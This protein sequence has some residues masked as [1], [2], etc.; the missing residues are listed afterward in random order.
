MTIRTDL[1]SP[2]EWHTLQLA[3]LWVFYL[4]AGADQEIDDREKLVFLQ[5][6]LSGTGEE[7]GSTEAGFRRDVLTSLERDLPALIRTLGRDG[8][9]PLT[10]LRQVAGV[11]NRKT[12]LET[13]V[14]FKESLM[15]IGNRVAGASGRGRYG[16]EAAIGPE[17]R[18]ALFLIAA[19]LGILPLVPIEGDLL[20]GAA[21]DD[22]PRAY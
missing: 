3:P 5:C 11:L 1:F 12:E 13:A 19:V 14:A 17:E 16:E 9:D 15:E 2:E 22:Q 7:D 18:Q 8:R 21:C 20:A 10:G 6:V 4:V